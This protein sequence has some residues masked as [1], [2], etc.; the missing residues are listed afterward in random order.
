M[1]KILI[2]G[3]MLVMGITA[4]AQ[5]DELNRS[6]EVTREFEPTLRTATKL[7]TTPNFTDTVALRPELRYGIR[8]NP[9]SYG[10]EVAPI[11][12]AEVDA[13][14]YRPLTPFYLKAGLGYPLRSVL[15]FNYSPEMRGRGT[16]GAYLNHYGS[17]SDI[18]NTAN[19]SQYAPYSYNRAGIYGEHR[20]G[21]MMV[22]G[23]LSYDYRL[24]SRYGATPDSAVA[25][26]FPDYRQTYNTLQASL[27][28]G[29]P[30]TD[31]SYFNFRFGSKGY[32]FFDHYNNKEINIHPFLEIGKRFSDR[33][34]LMLQGSFEYVKSTAERDEYRES[35]LK[36]TALSQQIYRIAPVYELVGQA[37]GFTLG[38]EYAYTREEVKLSQSR[39]S[40]SSYFFPKFKM[41]LDAF[42]GRFVP[43]LDIDGRLYTGGLRTASRLN[44]YLYAF[45]TAANTAVYDGRVGIRGD[46]GTAFSYKFFG[47]FSIYKDLNIIT[48]LLQFDP[49]LN[50]AET[51][52]AHLWSVGGDIS[53]R[54]SGAFDLTASFQYFGWTKVKYDAESLCAGSDIASGMPNFEGSLGIRYNYRDKFIAHLQGTVYGTTRWL[55]TSD[56]MVPDGLHSWGDAR[57]V[58]QFELNLELQ[59][60]ISKRFGIYVNGTN[61]TGSK[62]YLYGPFYPLLGAGFD[63]GVKLSF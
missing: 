40:N 33:H 32:Y 21:R 12:A 37:F 29:T 30:F 34:L 9:L 39:T 2:F 59:Y 42:E 36:G 61:L 45:S 56:R 19:I 27:V 6:M 49:A 57:I 26:L 18:T 23:D 16:L 24:V 25:D 31:L 7:N 22:G 50:M 44:P 13:S 10:F 48:S 15:D 20:F 60:N 41:Q 54:I 11:R 38:C 51:I 35:Y 46:I 43:Y 28:F 8:P 5:Q 17:F 3:I 52:D 62:L 55:V 14:V 53:G 58:P 47:G 4:R 1:K 63:A